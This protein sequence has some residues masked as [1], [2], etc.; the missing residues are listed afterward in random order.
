VAAQ[1]QDF[2]LYLSKTADQYFAEVAKSP[3][4]PSH[5][6]PL[7]LPFGAEPMEV[8]L[9][10]LENAVLKAR[11][12]RHG[13][14]TSEEAIVREFGADLFAAVFRT[15]AIASHFEKSLNLVQAAQ[16]RGLRLLLRVEPPELAMLPWEYMFDN[17]QRDDDFN[18]ICLRSASPVVRFLHASS[19]PTTL[20]VQGPLRILGMISNPTDGHWESLDVD[21]ERRQIEEVV[22]ALPG[23]VHFEWVKGGGY[24]DLF[25]SMQSGSWHVFHFIGHG[26]TDRYHSPEGDLRAEGYVVMQSG[27]GGSV[28]IS[29]STL[30]LV[31][32]DTGNTLKLAVLN[33]CDSGKGS[34]GLSSVGASLVSA[35]VPLVIA[36]QF[37]ISN[38][39]ATRFAGRFYRQLVS[40]QSVEQALTVARRF[41]R[42]QSNVEWGIPVLLT[43][44]GANVLF[45]IEQNPAQTA[46]AGLDPRS[47][48]SPDA[49]CQAR[50]REELRELFR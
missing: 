26:G 21:A 50:A 27:V 25:E 2:E 13:P 19:A 42:A 24:D 49:D 23:A 4:G 46:P 8:L 33:C 34:G 37:A 32:D 10:R 14:L 20:R 39:A 48:K 29:A 18:Y 12:Y 45:E 28:K 43:R 35:G 44:T 1:Y 11:G 3:A 36:M 41:M 9:L 31:L 40:G 38:G 7:R 6:V 47:N 15:D 16:D 5:R 22:A 17:S 30:G